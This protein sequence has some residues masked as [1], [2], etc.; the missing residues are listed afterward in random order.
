MDSNTESVKRMTG[1][2]QELSIILD[3]SGD[4]GDTILPDERDSSLI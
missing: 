2:R 1:V 4:R 3:D